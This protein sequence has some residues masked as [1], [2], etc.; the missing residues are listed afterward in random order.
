M[1]V[2]PRGN[3][4]KRI[5]TVKVY[6]E[7]KYIRG[8]VYMIHRRADPVLFQVI[9]EDLDVRIE[10]TPEMRAQL[11]ALLKAM[12]LLQMQLQHYLHPKRAAES[13]TKLGGRL[14]AAPKE[15]L[16]A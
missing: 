9:N 6:T 16:D 12:E 8:E 10:D 5:D 15:K 3:G 11:D 4:R 7:N 14:L 1:I 2:Q 13:L